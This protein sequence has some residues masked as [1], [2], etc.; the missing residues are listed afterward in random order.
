MS[1][2]VNVSAEQA[3]EI[4]KCYKDPVYFVDK[5]VWITN[6][7]GGQVI[8]VNM[9]FKKGEAFSYQ[10]EVLDGLAKGQNYLLLK[11]RRGG[12]SW[13]AAMWASHQVNFVEGA[14]ILF[15]SKTENHAIVLLDKVKF[16]LKN[17]GYK[18]T[19]DKLLNRADFLANEI[20]ID[21]KTTLGIAWRN[22]KGEVTS[23]STVKSLTS[24]SDAS[25]GES[26][27]FFFIDEF[28]TIENDEKLWRSLLPTIARGGQ[29]M[30]A[31]TP[32][33]IGN[34]FHRLVMDAE[35]KQHIRS[36]GTPAYV[37]RKVHYTETGLTEDDVKDLTM[38]ATKDDVAQEWDMSFL[39]SGRPVFN[40]H[41]LAA[42]Y[43][44]R[45]M[46][47]DI[48]NELNIYRERANNHI[49]DFYYYIG[50]DTALG[51]SNRRSEEKDYSS[52]C[53]LTKNGIQ[54]FAYHTKN[55]TI[56]KWAGQ[57][58]DNEGN[59]IYIPGTVSRLHKEWPGVML[60]EENGPG[61]TVLLN[62]E[63]PED[64]ISEIHRHNTNQKTKSRIIRNLMIAVESHQIIITDKFTYDCLLYFQ[65]G[66]IPGTYEAPV[67]YHDDPVMSLALAWDM[68]LREGGVEFGAELN[69]PTALGI[70]RISNTDLDFANDADMLLGPTI[71]MN[72]ELTT[73]RA[74]SRFNF[75]KTIDIAD[76]IHS[77]SMNFRN[78]PTSIYKTFR[79]E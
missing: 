24:S 12:A 7:A 6:S 36:D 61:E 73:S 23:I 20:Y 14:N 70:R 35:N 66:S 71:V 30:G 22:D 79:K 11:S 50:V 10:R 2:L 43:K 57:I 51:K 15:I 16:I 76:N 32:R 1:R 28:A 17:L 18:N 53:M 63:L 75:A 42:C 69:D 55:E 67:G 21:N 49:T 40:V 64:G 54:A 72:S 34:T 19:G 52:I 37:L 44:P 8:P 68:L 25:V 13:T 45:D 38:G 33:G 48:D 29:W 62:H 65:H 78:A 5:Y 46:Y 26:A 74:S 77:P 56:S 58:A 59:K 60:V 27:S 3:Q 4:I 31:S 47:L 39:Q 41:D 9:G